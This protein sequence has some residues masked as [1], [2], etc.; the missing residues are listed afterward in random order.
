MPPARAGSVCAAPTAQAR[1][2]SGARRSPPAS[3]PRAR[4]RLARPR[5]R[6]S[7]LFLER[8]EARGGAAH[9]GG[10][11]PARDPQAEADLLLA[12]PE[13]VLGD[14]QFTI[15]LVQP[16]Q[17]AEQVDAIDGFVELTGCAMAD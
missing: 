8:S 3:G 7:A 16:A 12:E 13:V 10:D 17:C 15:A 6:P 5:I 1:S 4:D 2:R 9:G 14:E 11:G